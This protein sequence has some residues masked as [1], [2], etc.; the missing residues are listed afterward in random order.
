MKQMWLLFVIMVGLTACSNEAIHENQAKTANARVG[1]TVIGPFHPL[2]VTTRD[3]PSGTLIAAD[4]IAVCEWSPGLYPEVGISSSTVA[5]GQTTRVEIPRGT[6]VLLTQ[7]LMRSSTDQ[8]PASTQTIPF[9]CPSMDS[10]AKVILAGREIEPGE[11]ISDASVLI[12]DWPLG[13]IP[14]HA[15]KTAQSVIGKTA[16][17]LIPRGTVIM[18]TQI[19][20]S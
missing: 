16:L 18:F 1:P 4:M 13:A 15:V 6:P 8:A 5:V 19:G 9:N 20:E 2:V 10:R 17:S 12:A 3:L 14:S 7:L 11:T